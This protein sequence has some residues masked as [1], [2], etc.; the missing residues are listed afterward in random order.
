MDTTDVALCGNEGRNV[1]CH[2][3]ID[4]LPYQGLMDTESFKRR[5]CGISR[6]LDIKRE[7]L[8]L[9]EIKLK[10]MSKVFPLP[11]PLITFY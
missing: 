2:Y 11:R 7:S 8:G 4:W 3:E 6:N 5:D 10:M 1:G 9:N